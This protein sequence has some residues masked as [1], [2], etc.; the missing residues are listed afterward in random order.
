MHPAHA[1]VEPLV[2]LVVLLHDGGVLDHIRCCTSSPRIQSSVAMAAPRARVSGASG[3]E[4]S[5]S[6][7]STAMVRGWRRLGFG[8]RVRVQE[9][10]VGMVGSGGVGAAWVR[11]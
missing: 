4:D 9:R 10:R 8:E 6:S 5:G 3:R 11:G 2:Q 1:A 7:P